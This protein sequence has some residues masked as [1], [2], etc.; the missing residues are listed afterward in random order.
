MRRARLLAARA[1]RADTRLMEFECDEPLGFVGG[2]FV[3][4][5]TGRIA[6]SGRPYRRA[7]SLLSPDREQRRFEIAVKRI[8][9][10][11]CSG[12][13]HELAVGADISFTGPWGD[14]HPRAQGPLL[15]LATDTGITAA[16]GLVRGAR[17]ASRL[18]ETTLVWLRTPSEYFLPEELVRSWIPRACAEVIIGELPPIGHAER[19]PHMRA[20]LRTRLPVAEAFIAGD[21]AVNYALLD[22]LVAAGVPATRDSLES[23]F[24][25]PRRT[26]S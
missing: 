13:L 18:H 11:V 10:G 9:D 4:V 26:A 5:D 3:S 12:L 20:W 24:N 14:F 8:D 2:Q 16:L 25:F 23:F 19:V 17:A 15:V 21:G 1:L 6:A 22:D 7:Y